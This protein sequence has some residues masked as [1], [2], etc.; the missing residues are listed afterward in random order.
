MS[1]WIQRAPQVVYRPDTGEI[2]QVIDR[3]DLEYLSAGESFRIEVDPAR[4]TGVF[5]DRI[6][7]N[8]VPLDRENAERLLQCISPALTLLLGQY[9]VC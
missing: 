5:R 4:V 1:S 7:K 6:V 9:E 2:L 3:Y 8:G